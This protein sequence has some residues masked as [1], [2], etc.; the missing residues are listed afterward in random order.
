MRIMDF[1]EY[2][3]LTLQGGD[4]DLIQDERGEK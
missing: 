2:R 3:P 1:V 4:G